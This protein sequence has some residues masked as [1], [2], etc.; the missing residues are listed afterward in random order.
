MLKAMHATLLILDVM[1]IIDIEW[2][3]V[4]NEM[5]LIHLKEVL[6]EV[7]REEY[8]RKYTGYIWYVCVYIGFL[9]SNAVG[10]TIK[11]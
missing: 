8:Y 6:L 11:R 1:Y 5:M 2:A 10:K 7:S 4:S 9:S 3:C